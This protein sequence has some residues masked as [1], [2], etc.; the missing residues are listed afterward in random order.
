MQKESV[1]T[2]PKAEGISVFKQQQEEGIVGPQHYAPKIDIT[3]PSKGGA[4]FGASKVER[5]P[6]EKPKE[7]PGPG[8]YNQQQFAI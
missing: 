6:M 2:R 1:S 7:G 5:S 3:R 8:A 4:N